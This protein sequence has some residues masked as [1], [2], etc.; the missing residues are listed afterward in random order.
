[1]EIVKLLKILGPET[2]IRQ[3]DASEGQSASDLAASIEADPNH[4][5]QTRNYTIHNGYIYHVDDRDSLARKPFGQIV[6]VGT[7]APGSLS[8]LD[9]GGQ[10]WRELKRLGF[11]VDNP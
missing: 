9:V 8:E 7:I 1:M 5:A 6:N 3:A 4:P 11:E 10:L 2:A